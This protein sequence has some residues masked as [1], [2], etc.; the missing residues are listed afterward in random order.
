[1]D[2]LYAEPEIRLGAAT[3]RLEL[4]GVIEAPRSCDELLEDP[5]FRPMAVSFESPMAFHYQ[6]LTSPWT[7]RNRRGR[8]GCCE[9]CSARRRRRSSPTSAGAEEVFANQRRGGSRDPRKVLP[10]PDPDRCFFHW[11]S[12]WKMYSDVELRDDLP[13]WINRHVGVGAHEGR[14]VRVEL[15]KDG[16]GGK[17]YSRPFI[18]YVGRVEFNL[19][20]AKDVPDDV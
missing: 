17:G 13:K 7:G 8:I 2:L 12:T 20:R 6:P 3:Y 9:Q 11:L 5:P 4:P 16:R 19:L 1:V 18:G 14:T 15:S 10:W